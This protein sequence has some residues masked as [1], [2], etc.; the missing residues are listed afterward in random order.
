MMDLN[1]YND[2]CTRK[3]AHYNAWLLDTKREF[4][5]PYP[6]FPEELKLAKK[7]K[8]VESPV[9]GNMAAVL[10]GTAKAPKATAKRAARKGSEGPK[11]GTKSQLAVEIY[12]RLAG[13]K[14]AVIQA[15]QD[16]LKM[17]LAGATTYFYNAK[18]AA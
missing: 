17:S 4:G 12:K 16:E 14:A 15:I 6:G 10:S 9:I 8:K 3:L 18:K 13:D 5:K 7:G 1:E 11:A 2:Y